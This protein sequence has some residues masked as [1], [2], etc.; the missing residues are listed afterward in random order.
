MLLGSGLA[1][2]AWRPCRDAEGR[3]PRSAIAMLLAGAAAVWVGSFGVVVGVVT[4]E[5][6]SPVAACGV[7]WRHLVAG[8]L[9][10]W[11]LALVMSWTVALP[12]RAVV[13]LAA[14]LL[15]TGRVYRR[16]RLLGTPVEDQDGVVALPELGTT[17]VTVGVLRPV[18]AVDV[19]F[20]A[21]ATP[22]ERAVVLT[23]EQAHRRGRHSIVELAAR[24]LTAPLPATS[25]VYEGVRRHLEALADDAAVRRHDRRTVGVA[26]GRIALASYP[27][28]GLGAS[29]AAVWRMQRLVQPSTRTGWRDRLVLSV[30]GLGLALGLVVVLGDAAAALGPVAAPTF[31]PL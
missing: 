13:A 21:A 17:A 1:I 14:A 12:L 20:W 9:G 28:A 5:V 26:L 10:W 3:A 18:I 27:A 29:G 31:C 4:G 2:L 6:G 16:F 22:Q 7:L 30:S 19:T 11:R 23:H 24:C 15:T 8:D 25:A